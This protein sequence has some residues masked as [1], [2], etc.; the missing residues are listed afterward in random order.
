[1]LRAH[2]SNVLESSQCFLAQKPRD[3]DVLTIFHAHDVSEM[4][5]G[6]ITWVVSPLLSTRQG[7]SEVQRTVVIY[8]SSY[9]S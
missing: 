3:N 6:I 8:H 2:L 7:E 4:A 1:M 5:L 9:S